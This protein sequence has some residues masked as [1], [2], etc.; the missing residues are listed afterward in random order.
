MSVFSSLTLLFDGSFEGLMTAFFEAYA[1]R[2]HPVA[3]YPEATCQLEFNR[4]YQ[5]VTTDPAEA[6]RVIRGIEQKIG[7]FAYEKVWLAF[8]ADLPDVSQAIYRY[9]LWGFEIGSVIR[10]RLADDRAIAVDK[11][12]ALVVREAGHLR[13]FLRFAEME[14][15]VFYGEIS[16]RHEVLPL[17]MPH[18]ADRFACQP[19]IV[20]DCRHQMAGVCLQGEWYITPSSTFTLPEFSTKEQAI[21]HLWRTFYH[22]VAIKERI[23]PALRRQLMP[24]KYWEHMTEMQPFVYKPRQTAYQPSSQ[25]SAPSLFSA[26]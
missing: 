24:K 26:G 14:G 19:F 8:C 16:P 13:E 7:S 15:G 18:F 9:L 25:P 2:P 6:D 1:R 21:Q 22:S 12:I 10:Q 20:Q 11:A 5:T 17:L 4:R 3:I 23:N